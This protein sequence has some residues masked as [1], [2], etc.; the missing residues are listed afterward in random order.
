MEAGGQGPAVAMDEMFL[1][2]ELGTK[3]GNTLAF[4]GRHYCIYLCQMVKM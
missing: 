1:L 2:E 4:P 3:L